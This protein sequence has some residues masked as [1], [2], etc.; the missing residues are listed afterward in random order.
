MAKPEIARIV[1]KD[2]EVWEGKVVG[3]QKGHSLA[4]LALGMLVPPVGL[5][6][7]TEDMTGSGPRSTTVRV[8]GVD[9]TGKRTS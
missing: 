4:D 8:N 7:A 2:G 9:H 1:D 3:E 5:V 6:M